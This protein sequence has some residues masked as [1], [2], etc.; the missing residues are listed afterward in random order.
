MTK[1]ELV[2]LDTSALLAMRADEPG[3]GV[4]EGLLRQAEETL[5]SLLASFMTRMELLYIIWRQEGEM[6]ARQAIGMVDTF[7]IEWISCEKEILDCAAL[8]KSRGGL[9]VADCWIAATAITR[10]AIL[11]HKD[12]EFSRITQLRQ[13]FLEG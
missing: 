6:A 13:Q 10:G 7:N 8:L 11:L 2:V 4:V 12:P 9:S 3:A 5:H 1:E